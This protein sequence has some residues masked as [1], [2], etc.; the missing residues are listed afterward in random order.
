M[1]NIRNVAKLLLVTG[2]VAV[3]IHTAMVTFGSCVEKNRC[4]A[5]V[6]FGIPEV[7]PL[8][9]AV[10]LG[11]AANSTLS[12]PNQAAVFTTATLFTVIQ[13]TGLYALMIG[14]S[15]LLLFEFLKLFRLFTR[16]GKRALS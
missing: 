4:L 3:S 7:E 16:K 2:A 12:L 15:G 6:Y 9:L 13:I 5:S 8:P 11:E 14:I 1:F 10:D